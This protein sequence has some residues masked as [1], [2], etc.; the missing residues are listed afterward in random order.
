M[1]IENKR[2]IVNMNQKLYDESCLQGDL[3]VENQ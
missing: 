2:F 3:K 1:S